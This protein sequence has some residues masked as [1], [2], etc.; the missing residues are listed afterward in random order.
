MDERKRR[1]L[2]VDDEPSIVK[3]VR[4]Q[5]ELAGFEVA[6]AINGVEALS[7][8]QATNP[9][10][11]IL[12]QMLPQLNGTEVC[13][14]LKHD[15]QTSH[16]PIMM[17]SANAKREDQQAML[18]K[19]ADAYMSKPFALEELLGQIRA[20]LDRPVKTSENA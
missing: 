10:L 13:D 6:I 19:G 9:E 16:I 14:K 7:Q 8:V 15:P 20:L 5:L 18:T 4:K 12:D 1:I 2:L 3:I 11:I 17:L